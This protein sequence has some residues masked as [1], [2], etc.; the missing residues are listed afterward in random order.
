MT[1]SRLQWTDVL[2]TVMAIA[3][4]T[5]VASWAGFREGAG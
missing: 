5:V 2:A 3:A 1:M 4:Y